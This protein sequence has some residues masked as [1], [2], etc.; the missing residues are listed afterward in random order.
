MDITTLRLAYEDLLEA[1]DEVLGPAD[2]AALAPPA[3]EWDALQVLGH[4]ALVDAATI[5]VVSTVAAGMH[6]TYD[7]RVTLDAWS[8]ERVVRLT[9]DRA[10]LRERIRTQGEVLG[11]LAEGLSETELDTLVP[12]RL[13]SGD[14]VLVDEPVPLRAIVAGIAEDH[15]PRHTDQLRA[16]LPHDAGSS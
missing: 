14:E 1:A 2:Q 7:N 15:L 16:L 6:A 4:V 10:G 3:G 11:M 5:A 8:I 13:V 9:G 12:A